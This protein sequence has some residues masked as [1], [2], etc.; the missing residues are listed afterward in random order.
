MLKLKREKSSLSDGNSKKEQASLK[1]KEENGSLFL[2]NQE[3][4]VI[5]KH[6]EIIN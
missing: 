1:D 5:V 4:F 6:I 2:Q 3:N